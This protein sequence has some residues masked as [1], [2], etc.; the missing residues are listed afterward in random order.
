MG[1]S[2][3][4]VRLVATGIATTVTVVEADLVASSVEVAVMVTVWAVA[5]AVQVE[6]DQVPA[7]E[8]QVTVLF[9]PPVGVELNTVLV[10]TVLVV[11]AGVTAPTATTWGVTVTEVVAV[12]PAALVTVKVKVLAPSQLAV[13]A[14]VA[15]PEVMEPML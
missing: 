15:E 9:A 11:A 10:L 14:L 4:A 1:V 12:V 3:E 7:V 13:I 6:P 8:D 5:G 2:E